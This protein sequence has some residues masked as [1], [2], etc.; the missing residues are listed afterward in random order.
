MPEASY[1]FLNPQ[2][3]LNKMLTLKILGLITDLQL[4]FVGTLNTR[5]LNYRVDKILLRDLGPCNS[6]L[7]VPNDLTLIS[8][9]K[10]VLYCLFFQ[11]KIVYYCTNTFQSIQ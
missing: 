5:I 8:M 1:V 11:I 6:V 4:F 2:S 3:I 7:C 10:L 9:G